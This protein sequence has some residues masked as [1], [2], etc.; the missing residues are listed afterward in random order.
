MTTRN[1]A[2][3]LFQFAR[4]Q[5]D[6]V[7]ISS[8]GEAWSYGET[9]RVAAALAGRFAAVRSSGRIGIL[10]SRSAVACLGILGTVWAGLTYVPLSLKLPEERLVE[11]LKALALDAIVIDHRGAGMISATVHE[12]LPKLVIMA[13]NVKPSGVSL[14][15]DIVYLT[16]IKEIVGG[17]PAPIDSD[18][19]AYIEFTSG[20]TGKPKGVM[21]PAIAVNNYLQV[22]QEWSGMSPTDRAAETCDITFDLSVHN[23]FLTWHGGASLH[24]MSA[25]QMLQPARFI[26]DHGITCWLSVPSIIGLMRK[27]NMLKPASLASLRISMFCGEPLPSGAAQAWLE[28][29]P[30]SR[31]D[32][33]YGPTEATIAC[34]RQVVETPIAVT[35]GRGIVAI[36]C[37]FP[38]MSVAVFDQHNQKVKVGVP[39]E[40]ALC[41]IQLARGYFGQPELTRERFPVIDG[42][43]WYLTGD[44]GV[45]D[46][47]GIFHHLGR[48]D[49]QIKIMGNRV[50]LEEVEMHLRAA[51]GSDEVAAVAWP[52][53]HG[54]A[55]GIVGFVVNTKLRPEQIQAS[56]AEKVA[57]YMM[58]SDLHLMDALPL[59]GNGKVDRAA[60]GILLSHGLVGVRDG[61]G[62]QSA[63]EQM[64]VAPLVHRAAHLDKAPALQG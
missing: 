6:A 45:E 13:A 43:R 63:L 32:N 41:G 15:K 14:G 27:T 16:D 29:A 8:G 28:A 52:I 26:R 9:A 22:M 18:N 35:A 51:S 59:N 5:P 58:P 33:I 19:I 17:E 61:T 38:G 7:A 64:T 11:L 40:I 31:V 20:T 47:N 50:E 57:S 21:V 1:L 54:S 4:S 12:Y 42:E 46:E 36:G 2:R 44:L 34:L 3:P 23:M 30:N 62:R 39:G 24:I 60:L 37:A 10:A 55:T 48:L 53:E 25:I 56:L 49:N